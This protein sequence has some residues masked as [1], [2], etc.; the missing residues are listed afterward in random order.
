MTPPPEPIVPLDLLALTGDAAIT[1]AR[2]RLVRGAEAA[3]AI[4]RQ[5]TR[6]GR[7]APEHHGLPAAAV[8][9]WRRHFT[10]RL[11][12]VVR[13]VEEHAAW[14][15]ETVK[16]V[17]E[18]HDGLPIEC[19]RIPRKNGRASLCVS[20]QVGCRQGCAFCQTAR[21][22]FRRDLSAAEIVG[23]V[24]VARATLG[25]S[26]DAVVFMGM[27]EPL[28]NL[29]NVITALRVLNDRRGLNIS[30]RHLAVCTAGLPAGIERLAALRW[31]RLGLAVSLTSAR[32]E[33]RASLMPIA[34]RV[35]LADLQ[36]ALLGYRRQLA[37]QPSAEHNNLVLSVN[38]CLLPGI[39]DTED[40]ARAVA[41]FI[42][43][44]GKVLVH[45][46]PYNPGS[47]P[48]TRAADDEETCRFVTRLLDHGVCANQRVA[49]GRA[50]MA[51][52]GQLGSRSLPCSAGS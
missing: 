30:R 40:D 44:L 41:A 22:G 14:G 37:P 35:S 5:A 17:L 18:T 48:I 31:R 7:F 8:D 2:A 26:I 52:C 49:K 46:I 20:S 33:T 12:R 15:A 6:E 39:N 3:R 16:L 28:D 47:S 45:V 27:G 21:M 36:R 50:V 1:A 11:P 32:E 34:R 23:Q 38:Y 19:V 9:D 24:V 42:E 10:L 43:P 25:W 29:D 13:Q 51:A 4:Y